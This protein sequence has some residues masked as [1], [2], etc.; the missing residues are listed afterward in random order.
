MKRDPEE[1]I[2][3]STHFFPRRIARKVAK[4][5]MEKAGYR[6]INKKF[7]ENWRSFV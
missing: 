4:S 3:P 2:V 6:K 7:K 1:K 5:N